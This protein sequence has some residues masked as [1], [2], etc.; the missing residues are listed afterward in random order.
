MNDNRKNF[1]KWYKIPLS[2]LYKNVDA[3]FIIMMVS[4][5][6]LER[7]LREKCNIKE[8]AGL[9]DDFYRTLTV[10]FPNLNNKENAKVFWK[11]YRHG[12]LHKTAL[13]I[14]GKTFHVQIA[15]MHN[16]AN[17]IELEVNKNAYKFMVSPV[18]VS[19]RTI[20]TI[21]NDFETYEGINSPCHPLPAIY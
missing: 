2:T 14:S 13:R 5:P 8:F 16:D 6:L 15:G 18:K 1:N 21:E 17:E 20:L 11:V 10:I 7:Y 3:G 9:N 19:R 12:L 4:L